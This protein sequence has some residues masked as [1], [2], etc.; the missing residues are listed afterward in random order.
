MNSST[1]NLFPAQ[2]CEVLLLDTAQR[3][4]FLIN[5]EEFFGLS[6][7]TPEEEEEQLCMA[8]QLFLGPI[9]SGTVMGR[10]TLKFDT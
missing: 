1:Q 2:K 9:P 5:K 3:E 8:K 4:M 10:K 7:N 6:Q